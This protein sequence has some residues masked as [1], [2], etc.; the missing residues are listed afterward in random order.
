M[1]EGTSRKSPKER[2][3]KIMR[4]SYN[5]PVKKALDRPLVWGEQRFPAGN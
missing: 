4:K 3:K 1:F 2:L 5:K